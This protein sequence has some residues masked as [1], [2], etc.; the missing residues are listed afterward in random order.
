MLRGAYLRPGR[1]GRRGSRPSAEILRKSVCRCVRLCSAESKVCFK[2]R[3]CITQLS[4]R[5]EL[6]SPA[7]SRRYTC[8]S[9]RYF[10]CRTRNVN[11]SGYAQYIKSSRG[12]VGG[13]LMWELEHEDSRRWLW[14]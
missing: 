6:E 14:P 1:E 3:R 4:Q 11:A 8:T 2:S 7:W 9:S 12:I 10:A 5:L 13:H